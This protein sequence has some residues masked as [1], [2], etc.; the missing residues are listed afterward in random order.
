[1]QTYMA[2]SCLQ[3]YRSM[4]SS[5]PCICMHI[6]ASTFFA[7]KLLMY[8]SQ[9]SSSPPSALLQLWLVQ[10]DFRRPCRQ[11]ML[12]FQ[13]MRNKMLYLY[14][15]MSISTCLQNYKSM[16]QGHSCSDR[17]SQLLESSVIGGYFS[18]ARLRKN[19]NEKMNGQHACT[20]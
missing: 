6:F 13:N 9:G 15:Y 12:I 16:Q 7:C 1:M 19:P 11:N 14:I 2:G 3:V 5:S 20:S 10:S 8:C 4:L 17:C 18:P